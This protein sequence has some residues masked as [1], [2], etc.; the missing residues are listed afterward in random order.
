[1]S[2]I[3]PGDYKVFSWEAL[4]EYAWFDPELLAQSETRGHAVRTSESSTETIE[5]RLIPAGGTP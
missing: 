3:A 1:M 5:V 2:G 4:E